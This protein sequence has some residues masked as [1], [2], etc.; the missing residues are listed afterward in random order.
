MRRA[1]LPRHS[2][3]AGVLD[4][5]YTTIEHAAARLGVPVAW[6]RREA[7]AGTVPSLRV[8]RRLL[9]DVEAVA[10]ALRE[11]A[12]ERQAPGSAGGDR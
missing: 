10:E 8:G 4:A 3:R 9:F 7:E 2:Y 1:G 5:R 12:A 6:L 11:R